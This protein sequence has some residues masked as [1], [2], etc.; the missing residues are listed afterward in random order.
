MAEDQEIQEGEEEVVAEQERPD[1]LDPKFK[2]VEDQARAF[3]EAEREKGR[4]S[5]EIGGLRSEM[6]ELT[7]YVENLPA[8]Q[9]QNGDLGQN[10][11]VAQYSR[12]F[13]EGDVATM[14]AVQAEIARAAAAQ[15]APAVPE[16]DYGMLTAFAENQIRQAN[17]DYD[18]Y[19]SQTVEI[20]QRNPQLIPDGATLDTVQN[21]IL[22]A[23]NA[24]RGEAALTQQQAQAERD[25]ATEQ[26]QDAKRQA[27]T[28]PGGG[29]RPQRMDGEGGD[30]WER[31]KNADTGG[32]RLPT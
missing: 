30:I 5:T 19:R 8:Q 27:Q 31:I 1:W 14:L 21:G 18:Q 29:S 15:S 32:F 23:L 2:S 12:A 7:A 28:V 3:N 20:L 4:L 9:P 16:Q 26:A 10:P 11:L 6:D 17:P 22:M 13:E 25:R 24:A